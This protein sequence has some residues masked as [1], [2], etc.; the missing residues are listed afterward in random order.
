MVAKQEDQIETGNENLPHKRCDL[1]K[2]ILMEV[3]VTVTV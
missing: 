2:E 3:E 1:K